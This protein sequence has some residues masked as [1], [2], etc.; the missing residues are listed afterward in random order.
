MRILNMTW[1][2]TAI[3]AAL[4]GGAAAQSTPSEQEIIDALLP[5]GEPAVATRS[6]RGVGVSD[7]SEGP[8]SISLQVHFAYDSAELDNESLLTLNTLG[9]ALASEQLR[10]QAIEVVGH[11]D[12]RG[13]ADYNDAAV[14][15]ACGSSGGLSRAALRPGQI[16]DPGQGNGGT[17]PRRPGLA[18]SG[19][20]PAGR[21]PQRDTPAVGDGHRLERT[22][23]KGG[24]DAWMEPCC[25]GN[26][27][28]R[29]CGHSV[30][31][32][33]RSGGGAGRAGGRQ[34]RL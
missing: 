19:R 24:N 27:R 8:P 32:N 7:A 3:M 1:L 34:R 17:R 22:V 29:A 18:G 23:E 5:G 14:R 15:A 33:E 26:C 10:E 21:D 9:R 20:E 6:L 30:A 16:E 11:T 2:V 25:A 31:D 12:A 4:A 13:P 28:C